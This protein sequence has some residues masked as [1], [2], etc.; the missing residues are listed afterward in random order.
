MATY[1]VSDFSNI[2]GYFG[3]LSARSSKHINMQGR[4]RGIVY[5]LFLELETTKILQSVWR[6]VAK[7]VQVCFL[8]NYKPTKF[9]WSM[10]QISR[11]SHI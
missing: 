4:A 6:G 9:Q 3:H 8:K 7:S 5:L 11:D 2:K 10:L 1:W